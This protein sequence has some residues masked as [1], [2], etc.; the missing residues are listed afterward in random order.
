VNLRNAKE[1]QARAIMSQTQPGD[2]VK[3]LVQYNLES[4][5]HK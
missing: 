1:V 5:P 4:K 3:F 2:N